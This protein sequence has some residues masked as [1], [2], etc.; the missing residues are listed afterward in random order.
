MTAPAQTPGE[1]RRSARR[2]LERDAR[3]VLLEAAAPDADERRHAAVMAHYAAETVR[4]S[5]PPWHERPVHAGGDPPEP[6]DKSMGAR[7]WHRARE[8][9]DGLLKQNQNHYADCE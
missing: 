3:R 1:R 7:T 2:L 5:L 8:L 4:F 6:S 9:R